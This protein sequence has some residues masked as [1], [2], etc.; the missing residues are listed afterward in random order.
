MVNEIKRIKENYVEVGYVVKT[1]KKSS[2]PTQEGVVAAREGLINY[3]NNY[4]LF[5]SKYQDFLDWHKAYLIKNSRKNMTPSGTSEL[6]SV[7]NSMNTKRTQF[8]WD[9]LNKFYI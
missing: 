5:S 9:S 7:K 3:L 4:P 8:N 2:E 1:I 6:L